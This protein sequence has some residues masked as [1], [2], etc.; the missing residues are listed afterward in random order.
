MT[1]NLPVE[2]PDWVKFITIDGDGYVNGFKDKPVFVTDSWVWGDISK[3]YEVLCLTQRPEN[4][5]N[6][7]Y[8]ITNGNLERVESE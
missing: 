4:A 3:D 7:I 6:E 5:S 8:Q 2:V 1:I